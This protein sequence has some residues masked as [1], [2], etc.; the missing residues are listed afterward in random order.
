MKVY[1]K[2]LRITA[3][4]GICAL[5]WASTASAQSCTTFQESGNAESVRESYVL[6]RDQVKAKNFEAALP[7]WEQVYAKAPAADGK[8][9]VVYTDGVKIYLDLIKKAAEGDKA[10]YKEKI[11]ALYNECN[12]CLEAGKIKLPKT[13][14][15]K[16][17]AYHTGRKAYN[18]FYSLGMAYS[19]DLTQQFAAAVEKGGKDTE[20]ILLHPYALQVVYLFTNEKM[21]KAIARD[22]YTKL[23]EVADHNIANN[24]RVKSQYE[25]AKAAM[26]AEFK[27][28]ENYIFDCEYFVNKI[29]P[30]FEAKQDD[31]AYL[32]ESIKVLKRQGCDSTEAFLVQL[33]GKWSKYAEIE[34][35]R[36]QAEFEANNPGIMAKKLYDQKDYS[37]AITK[38]EEAIVD[39]EDASKKAGYY[40]SIASIQFRKLKQYSTARSTA[41]K[42]A[43]LRPGWGRPYMLI[44]DMYGSSARNCGDD[45]N[46]R[47]AILAAI[48]KYAYA[49]SID[50]EVAGDAR[51]RIAKYSGSK[52]EKQEG[53]MR[54]VKA[55]QTVTC[56]CWIG[57]SVKV[58]FK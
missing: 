29:K 58:S 53:F 55:G 47:I 17:V 4:L 10:K 18:M 35:A 23:N 54:G 11:I 46:Q 45:W 42:A 26:N 56:G 57:E 9:D 50:P 49:K 7:L 51:S 41:R 12:A 24:A 28:I 21:D 32:K 30:E 20:Y 39:E 36:I 5:A 33:E 15:E 13:P 48:D 14:S 43:E 3:L 31:P 34:N 44:G 8:R 40:F 1:R 38:Y 25:S 16:R 52:P 27:K 19:D 2:V 22:I 37:G 6:Y